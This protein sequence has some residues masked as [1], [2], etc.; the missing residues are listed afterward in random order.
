MRNKSLQG[1]GVHK[2]LSMLHGVRRTGTGRWIAS[3]PA[4]DDL[5]PSLSIRE[6]DD[7]LVLLHDFG[8]C[9]TSDVLASVGL[10]FDS[11]YPEAR[12]SHSSGIRRPFHTIDVLRCVAF[13]AL[14]VCVAAS[15]MAQGAIL[16]EADRRRMVLAGSRLQAAMEVCNG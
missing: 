13:E 10:T 3:C 5:H 7:G 8:G 6:L 14:V 2:L 4:H 12:T 9:S 15:R 16:S 11:L 1:M